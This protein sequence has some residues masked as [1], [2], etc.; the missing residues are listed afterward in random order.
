MTTI[1]IPLSSVASEQSCSVW[2]W[3]ALSADECR[4]LDASYGHR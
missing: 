4:W 2:S 1:E 3:A